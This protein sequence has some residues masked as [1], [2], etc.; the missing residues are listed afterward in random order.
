[1]QARS[2]LYILSETYICHSVVLT[3][4]QPA[5]TT[6]RNFKNKP[7]N[8]RASF[9][10]LLSRL[11]SDCLPFNLY[12]NSFICS[13]NFLT[14]IFYSVC[15]IWF[16]FKL[17]RD[18]LFTLY[19]RFNMVMKQRFIFKKKC[20]STLHEHKYLYQWKWRVQSF[21]WIWTYG[22][23]KREKHKN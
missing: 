16:C 21:Q 1:M 13:H 10:N 9:K 15:F 6:E 7:P 11:K 18:I 5:K 17:S 20:S 2:Y 8:F 12:L 22:F 19:P 3:P 14:F 23:Q 4:R